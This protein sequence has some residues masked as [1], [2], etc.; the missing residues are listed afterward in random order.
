MLAHVFSSGRN[1]RWSSLYWRVGESYL[2]WDKFGGCILVLC[3]F[4]AWLTVRYKYTEADDTSFA[5][6]YFKSQKY[7]EKYFRTGFIDR[8]CM[9]FNFKIRDF[10][11]SINGSIVIFVDDVKSDRRVES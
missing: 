4:F 6:L 7:R 5:D 10:I 3:R 1:K 9:E 8:N 2:K 11:I